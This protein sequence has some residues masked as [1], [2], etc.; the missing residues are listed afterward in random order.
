MA[1]GDL[2]EAFQALALGQAHVDK[3]C[4][5][6]LGIGED[7]KLLDGGV[8]AH[9]AFKAWVGV[10]PLLRGLAEEGDVEQ[11]G[12]GGVGDGGLGGG[13]FG[14]DEVLFYRV[15]VDAVVEL[16]EGAVEVPRE[17]E[18]AAFVFFEALE[19]LDEGRA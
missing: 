6:S 1:D 2:I 15:G 8:V 17:R 9:V 14:R 19:F 11:V 18:A 3:F 12:F 7:E 10:A 16:R 4:V 5:H 13:D